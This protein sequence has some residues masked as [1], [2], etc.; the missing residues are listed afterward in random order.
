M[1]QQ[2]QAALNAALGRTTSVPLSNLRRRTLKFVIDP[3]QGPTV[4][5]P[6][7]YAGHTTRVP[8]TGA[9]IEQHEH[10]TPGYGEKVVDL[11]TSGMHDLWALGATNDGSLLTVITFTDGTTLARIVPAALPETREKLRDAAR[12]FT[13]WANR[14]VNPTNPTHPT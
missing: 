14:L 7:S 10:G 11:Y 9:R 1:N 8:A 3:T 6:T 4:V 12:A 5:I 2:Q 13:E